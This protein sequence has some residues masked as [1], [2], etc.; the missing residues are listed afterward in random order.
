MKALNCKVAK[1]MDDELNRF[2]TEINI[3]NYAA[4]LGYQ[5]DKQKSG[6]NCTIMRKANAKIGVSTDLDD[7][8]VF[9]DFRKEKGGSIID[10][11]KFETGKNL[12]RVRQ[13]LRPWIGL[14]HPSPKQMFSYPKPVKTSKDRRKVAIKI[15]K[16]K[17][18]DTHRY[19][20]DRGIKQ[21]NL[22]SKR[23]LGKIYIDDYGNAI[24][25]HYDNDGISGFSIINK[26]FK[27][28]S[29]DG[30]RGLWF[31]NYYPE[32]YRMVICESVIDA[33]SYH[34]LKGDNVSCYL[35]IDGQL[36]QKQLMLIDGL[37]SKNQNKKIV[38]AFDNDHAGRK[39]ISQIQKQHKDTDN[40]IV[41]L[42]E[43]DGDDW[44]DALNKTH[45]KMKKCITQEKEGRQYQ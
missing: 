13:E 21:S 8:G 16:A 5:I 33:L 37:V 38:L 4:S 7:H 31:S 25:P 27:G 15:A 29:Q 35:S 34:E 41:D 30:E 44:N 39:Y 6:K 12:G 2:K 19:I 18:I 10:F 1:N 28:F 14:D 9:F 17:S 23:F 32:D 3:I 40:I 22:K 42:P 45:V 26:N 43:N 36:T 24:F 20:E 11:V